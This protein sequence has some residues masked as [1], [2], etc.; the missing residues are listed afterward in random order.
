MSTPIVLIIK[1]IAPC[2]EVMTT[3]DE[4]FR[5]NRDQSQFNYLCLVWESIICC[6]CRFSI[7]KLSVFINSLP[8]VSS[9]F[10][11]LLCVLISNSRTFMQKHS[12]SLD[13][14][15][16]LNT[17]F[18]F[19]SSTSETVCLFNAMNSILFA[20]FISNYLIVI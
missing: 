1:R 17:T 20:K 13:E 5:V 18:P 2:T 3:G 8:P 9:Q 4:L 16:M 6:T 19:S 7:T 11:G 15:K 12:F 14:R 10:M